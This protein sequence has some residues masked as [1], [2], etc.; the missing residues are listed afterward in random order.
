MQ[1]DDDEADPP[2]DHSGSGDP[3]R[4]SCDADPADRG[5]GQTQHSA[6]AADAGD[7]AR[8][9]SP[10]GHD[11]VLLFGFAFGGAIQPQAVEH[12]YRDWLLPGIM[13]QTIA[14]SCSAVAVGLATDIQ[15]GMV[16]RL[17]SLPIGRSVLLLG[18][19]I[20]GLIHASMGSSS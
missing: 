20:S 13:G 1:H 10:A 6:P 15:S 8:R 7:S 4:E 5:D 19:S 9:D 3:A 16:D 2:G 14:W 17:R 12:G 11:G 18:R